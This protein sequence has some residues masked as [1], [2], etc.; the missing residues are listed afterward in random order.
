MNEKYI[1][2]FITLLGSAVASILLAIGV[3]FDRITIIRALVIL[4]VVIII[5]YIIGRIVLKIYRKI[6]TDV[7]N[8][9]REELAK[10]LEAQKAEDDQQAD[11]EETQNEN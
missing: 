7:V 6:H 4:I 9:Q 5:F 10:Q 8:R 3:W 1:A 2:Q 11:E